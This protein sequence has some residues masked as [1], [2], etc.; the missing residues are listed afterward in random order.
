MRGANLFFALF[1]LPASFELRAGE[2]QYSRDIQP[3]L[4]ENCYSCHGPDKENRKADLRLDLRE[5]VLA[6]RGGTPAV[7]PGHSEK[8]EL[9]RAFWPPM[10]TSV[11]RRPRLTTNSPTPKSSY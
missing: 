5:S 9:V 2:V 6:D 10:P 1:V 4:A 11:C 7:V 8:S 3:I